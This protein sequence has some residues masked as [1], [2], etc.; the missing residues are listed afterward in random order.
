MKLG[1]LTVVLG[2]Q[3]LKETLS[4]LKSLGVQQVEIGCGGYPGT[5][6]A[7]ARELINNPSLLDEFMSTIEESGI[8]IAAYA[9]HGNPLH[10]NKLIADEFQKDFDS[11][12]LL[13]EKT[14]VK[15]VVGFSGCP[16]DCDDSKYPNWVVSAWPE[17]FQK[18][19]EWQWKEKLIPYWK[20]EC[21][22]ANSH[23]VTQIALEMHPGFCVYNPE[24]LLRLRNAVGSTIGA[25]F[26]PSH[27]FWQGIDP[28]AAIRT[29]QGAIQHFHAKDTKI[30]PYLT[31]VN[32]ILDT[33]SFSCV[34][35]RSWIFRTVGYGHSEDTWKDIFSELRK[36]GYDG[37]I[38][39]EHEDGLMTNKEGLEKAV[40][41][42]KRSIIFDSQQINMFWA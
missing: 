24:T 40:D 6:H 9:C 17:D 31:S 2:N 22:F 4:Y 8:D 1:V 39:I 19:K 27:L 37:V 14:G 20:K 35:R 18:I 5:A 33:T 25:N 10:P 26:D 36:V 23:G 42:L 12:I 21:E 7:N 15:T 3:P 13:A 28:V 41:L 29:L 34:D 11:A 32:G 38:S 16:G 30:D